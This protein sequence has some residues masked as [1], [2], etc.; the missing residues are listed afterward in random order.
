MPLNKV[1][2]NGNMYNF[3]T[4]TWNPVKGKCSHGCSYC[5]MRRWGE[6][7][8]IRLDEKELKTKIGKG[9][10]IF[11]GSGTDM[12]AEDVPSSWIESVLEYC[13]QW[14]ESTYLFQTKNPGRY[15]DFEIPTNYI[16]GT[17]IET[18]RW[19]EYVMGETTLPINRCRAMAEITNQKFVTIEPVL[20]FD[21]EEFAEMINTIKPDWVNIGADSCGNNL[22][23]PSKEKVD[24]LISL[25]DSKIVIKKNLKRIMR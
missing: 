10:T 5:Y 21:L 7:K 9:K 8:P 23:E 17:T 15:L 1:S 19:D 12:W 13:D 6:Q 14:V 11:V 18:N 4:H 2:K 25:L 22:P 20:E 3:V 24:K 16:L